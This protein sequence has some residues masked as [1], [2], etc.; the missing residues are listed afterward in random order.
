MHNM[1]STKKENFGYFLP[2]AA[3]FLAFLIGYI[4]HQWFYPKYFS[5]DTAA[6]HILAKSVL[7]EH[8]L[9]PYDFNYGNQLIFFRSSLFIAFALAAGFTGYQAFIVGSALSIAFW[10]L[11]LHGFVSAYLGSQKKGLLFTCMLLLP[12]GIWEVDYVLGQQSHL[13]NVVL[14][15]GVVISLHRYLADK[16]RRF[17]ITAC[18]CLFAMSIEAP[19]RGLLVLAPVLAAITLTANARALRVAGFSTFGVFVLAMLANKALVKLHPLKT[20]HFKTLSFKSLDEFFGNLIRTS[21]EAISSV[22]SLNFL[23]GTKLSALGFIIF[24]LGLLLILAYLGFILA[25]TSR[26]LRLGTKKWAVLQHKQAAAPGYDLDL[27]RL[28]AVLGVLVGAVAVSALNPDSARHYLWAVFLIKLMVFI[29]LYNA[30][31][32]VIG[33]KWVG[34]TVVLAGLI[35]SAWAANLVVNKGSVKANSSNRKPSQAALAIAEVSKQTGIRH[36]YGDDFWRMMP[37]NTT[38]HGIDAQALSL[39]DDDIYVDA[40]LTRPSWSCV[41]GNVLYLLKDTPVDTRIMDKL[42][43]AGGTEIRAVDGYTLWT[44]PQVWRMPSNTPC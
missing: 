30:A 18:V 28:T 33:K 20:D 12:L 40:W 4:H 41:K 14:A 26:A 34:A 43:A 24:A 15:L 19:I 9:I 25:G 2:F 22:S 6:M 27:V 37:L 39:K 16:K 7:A 1:P 38:L 11:V 21:G 5:G 35:L 42:R 10:G 44:G 13:S 31:A 17:L 8:A 29:G 32:S 36:V 23:S 3:A